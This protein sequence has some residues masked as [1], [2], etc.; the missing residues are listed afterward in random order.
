MGE[1]NV[2]RELKQSKNEDPKGTGASTEKNNKSQRLKQWK[3]HGYNNLHTICARK[4]SLFFTT[5]F[6]FP[7]IYNLFIHSQQQIFW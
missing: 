3:C 6:T 2:L 4:I 7:Y 1:R 5:P